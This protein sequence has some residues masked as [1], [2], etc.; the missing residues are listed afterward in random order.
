MGRNVKARLSYEDDARYL[1]RLAT[2]V[3]IDEVASPV[4]KREVIAA[5][6]LVRAKFLNRS[7]R[8]ISL[9]EKS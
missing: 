9:S 2:A 7:S 8:N 6:N 3:E 5:L 1:L 4:W